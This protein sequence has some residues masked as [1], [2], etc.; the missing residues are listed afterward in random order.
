MKQTY[1]IRRLGLGLGYVNPF[2][3][4]RYSIVKLHFSRRQSAQRPRAERRRFSRVPFT[5]HPGVVPR[6][7]DVHGVEEVHLVVLL[8]RE[9]LGEEAQDGLRAAERPVARS[10]QHH[11]ST[12]RSALGER[13]DSVS[14]HA[15]RHKVVYGGRGERGI[16][17]AILVLH[18]ER[19]V[20]RKSHTAMEAVAKEGLG[21]NL[22]QLWRPWRE[23][24]WGEIL[25]M[26][27]VA[28]EG[29]DVSG[30]EALLC[31][32]SVSHTQTSIDE[33]ALALTNRVFKGGSRDAPTTTA[34]TARRGQE[35]TCVTK[36]RPPINV[37]RKARFVVDW[38]VID[39]MKRGYD[40][41]KNP[42]VAPDVPFQGGSGSSHKDAPPPNF[43]QVEIRQG[44]G[45]GIRNYT[46]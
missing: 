35:R 30:R 40:M 17:R 31:S 41:I 25:V 13:G 32:N 46:F 3:C 11:S 10:G 43:D 19:E 9:G 23:R 6:L 24:G 33:T 39:E 8:A 45:L 36:V 14:R 26:E 22:T 7:L 12:E 29:C 5:T 42:H 20:G 34:A 2:R 16:G 38:T 15:W 37:H 21:R 44:C 4:T 28:R 1:W 27:A 18:G